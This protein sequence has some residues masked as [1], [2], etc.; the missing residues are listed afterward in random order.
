M[1]PIANRIAGFGS[2]KCMW[3]PCEVLGRVFHRDVI[4]HL[5]G[6]DDPSLG[7]ELSSP[8]LCQIKAQMKH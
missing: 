4:W 5:T 1:R 7:D 3:I 6:E 8:I 2:Y